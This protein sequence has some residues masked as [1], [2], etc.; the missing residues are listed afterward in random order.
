MFEIKDI[1]DAFVNRTPLARNGIWFNNGD[2]DKAQE[3]IHALENEGFVPSGYLKE[4]LR[5]GV[6]DISRFFL[7]NKTS[8]FYSDCLEG[9]ELDIN[10]VNFGCLDENFEDLI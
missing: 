8:I 6:D 5:D 3:I 9:P 1:V 4:K 7:Y 2:E 10:E